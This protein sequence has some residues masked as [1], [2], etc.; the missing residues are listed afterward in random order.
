MPGQDNQDTEKQTWCASELKYNEKNRRWLQW[1]PWD[2]RDPWNPWDP[3]QKCFGM[4]F[5][6]R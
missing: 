6:V 4:V 3:G 2:P 5:R 1:D